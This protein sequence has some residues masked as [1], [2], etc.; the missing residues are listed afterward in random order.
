MNTYNRNPASTDYVGYF[1]STFF[2]VFLAGFMLLL[3]QRW[4]IRESMKDVKEATDLYIKNRLK[5]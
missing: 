2:A 5:K 4:Y 3:M 1:L